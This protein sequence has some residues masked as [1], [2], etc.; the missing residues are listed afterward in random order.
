MEIV[1]VF[2]DEKRK[3]IAWKLLS[4]AASRVAKARPHVDRLRGP[5]AADAPPLQQRS[6]LP[7]HGEDEGLMTESPLKPKG[8][9]GGH[10]QSGGASQRKLCEGPGVSLRRIRF[11]SL[12]L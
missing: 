9:L 6:E 5:F 4:Q 10:A 7:D 1:L 11:Q 8:T 12:K 2:P 3:N